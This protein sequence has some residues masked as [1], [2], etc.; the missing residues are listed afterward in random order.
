MKERWRIHWSYERRIAQPNTGTVG[1]SPDLI[2][3]S[4]SM[5]KTKMLITRPNF[6]AAL[7]ILGLL[8]WV[9]DVN[10]RPR[11][12][13]RKNSR[14][15]ARIAAPNPEIGTPPSRPFHV[16]LLLADG[17][18][19]DV[20][21]AWESQQGIWYKKNGVSY[22]GT[23]EQVKAIER[24]DLPGSSATIPAIAVTKPLVADETSAPAPTDR[25][26]IHLNGGARMEADQIQESAA[27]V[28][29]RRGSLSI[30]IDRSRI[31]HIER[32]A[33]EK[34]LES[35]SSTVR[36]LGW[37]SGNGK[38][39][40]LIKQNGARHGVDPYLIF[41]VMEQE[42]HFNSRVVSPKGAAGL[43]QLMP[44]TSARFGVR[45]PFSPAE[46]IS[47]GTRY[48][49]QLLNQFD[50]RIDLV[51]AGYNAGEG[52]VVRFGHRVP[53]Y[54]ETRNYVKR[55]SYRYQRAKAPAAK[56]VAANHAATG[57]RR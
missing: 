28:W 55:I 48:L 25:T 15:S 39:D 30:F 53:P 4:I 9:G 36:Q 35:E 43:M 22:L 50:G 26:W 49:K 31:D 27:G 47:A 40:T 20:D 54:S 24:G 6:R 8:I 29:Y 10:A 7:L 41:C 16:R 38:I 21:E 14:K 56:G 18:H 17:S 2:F 57:A 44:G 3:L 11:T 12:R 46:N 32:E 34:G 13:P 37:S 52:A 45:H 5:Q 42:S 19:L 33:L 23:S 1:V 51:L